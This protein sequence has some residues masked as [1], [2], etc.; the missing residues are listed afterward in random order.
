MRRTPRRRTCAGPLP[1]RT[2]NTWQP[3]TAYTLGTLVDP[4]DTANGYVYQCVAAGTS[5]PLASLPA[6]QQD[7]FSLGDTVNQLTPAGAEREFDYRR[8][9]AVECHPAT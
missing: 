3:A 1:P 7:P 2:G 8:D 4:I 6:N 5:Q 9:C